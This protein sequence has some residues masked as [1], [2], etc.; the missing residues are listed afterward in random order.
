MAQTNKKYCS[1]I[2]FL[3]LKVATGETVALVL[4][5]AEPGMASTLT[6]NIFFTF[7]ISYLGKGE[8]VHM[9]RG[10]G[11]RSH[12]SPSPCES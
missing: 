5:Q 1:N 3:N 12:F 9:V 10:R 2:Q 6:F 11:Q 4:Q 8:G 7:T